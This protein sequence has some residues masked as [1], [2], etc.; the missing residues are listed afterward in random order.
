[1]LS[2]QL[3][4]FR[5]FYF[6]SLLI[7]SRSFRFILKLH[8]P[9]S[10]TIILRYFMNKF[11]QRVCTVSYSEL[12]LCVSDTVFLLFFPFLFWVA[13][14]QWN[15][16]HQNLSI[17]LTKECEKCD[18][19]SPLLLK[20]HRDLCNKGKNKIRK[21]EEKTTHKIITNEKSLLFHWFIQLTF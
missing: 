13:F 21:Y 18:K 17:E 8:P 6:F 15:K 7:F 4:S 20:L 12:K 9:L 11:Q 16:L 2:L 10:S 3:S 14:L 1:M 19:I 5:D